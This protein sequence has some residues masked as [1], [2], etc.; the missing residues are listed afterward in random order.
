MSDESTLAKRRRQ[1]EARF[2]F[3]TKHH[4]FKP[5]IHNMPVQCF[6]WPLIQEFLNMTSC[7][8]NNCT[9]GS[10][11]VLPNNEINF[12]MTRYD[13]VLNLFGSLMDTD[14]VGYCASFVRVDLAAFPKLFLLPQI[15][16]QLITKLLSE[17]ETSEA[18][19]SL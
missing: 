12:T 14:H 7:P 2:N 8:F 18:S 5:L 17:L 1:M 10:F 13:P 16:N 3:L 9:H 19:A 4:F 6:S 11:V 15:S